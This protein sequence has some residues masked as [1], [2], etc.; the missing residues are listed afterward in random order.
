M[1]SRLNRSLSSVKSLAP[2]FQSL[3][4]RHT[5]SY[6]FVCRSCG[7]K[8]ESEKMVVDVLGALCSA[9]EGST[10]ADF[11]VR[12]FLEQYEEMRVQ[13]LRLAIDG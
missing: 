5:K 3:R 12:E 13:G 10:E 11:S 6:D 2:C 4:T 1:K 7:T 8:L 9:M